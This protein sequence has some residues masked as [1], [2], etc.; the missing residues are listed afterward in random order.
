MKKKTI[1]FATTNEGKIR[2][3]KEMLEPLGYQILSL[4]DVNLEVTHP[5]DAETFE[6]NSKIKAEDIASKCDY[7]VMADDS[8]L[9]ID[10]LDG[11]P[12]VHSARF[13]EGHPYHEKNQAIIDMLKDKPTR[14][15]SYFTVV[16]YL[17]KKKG[18]EVTF[19]GENKGEIATVIDEHP[20]NGFGYDPIFISYDLHKPF[21]QA[22]PEEKDSVSHRG[23]AVKALA[24]YLKEHDE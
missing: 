19:P 10:A 6:G 2:E 23:R 16:T 24:E 1:V 8:G 5:E 9:S 7:P 21:S 13:M 17:D 14:A 12:G 15:A 3:I 11:F 18:V 20:I 4:K 22:T